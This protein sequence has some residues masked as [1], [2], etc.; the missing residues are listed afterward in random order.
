MLHYS[1]IQ[2]GIEDNEGSLVAARLDRQERSMNQLLRQ[3]QDEAYLESLRVDREKERKKKEEKQKQDEEEK[4]RKEKEMDEIKKHEQLLKLRVDLAAKIPEEPD[5]K[6][7]NAIRILI[8]LPDGHRF[9]RKFLK[10][11][12]IKYLYY[13][14]FCQ[15]QSPLNFQ[16]T[17][18][19][20]RKELPCKPPSLEDPECNG[21]PPVN[22]QQSNDAMNRK[23][24]STRKEPPTFE[25]IGLGKSEMLFVHDLEA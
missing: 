3:E 21:I 5:A 24:N 4:Q 16:I 8:K 7:P 2:Q 19:F 9:E 11:H 15:E 17:T 1:Q 10:T 14:V 20:P 23:P 22:D 18:N 13:F 12:S 6:D 25:E